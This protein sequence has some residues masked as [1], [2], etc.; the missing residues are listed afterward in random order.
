M[1]IGKKTS[2][3]EV[4]ELGH[5]CKCDACSV[6]CR[7][8]SG[9]LINEDIPK[10]AN[11]LKISEEVLKKEFLEEVEK[12]NTKLFRPKIIRKNK[13]Y[14]KC[15][16]FDEETGCKVHEVKP[17]ECKVSMGCKPYGEQLSVWFMLNNFV[18]EN[19]AESIRQYASYLKSGG[20]ILEGAELKD[21]VPDEDKL[22][23]ILK[24]EILK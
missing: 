6:G 13:P 17:Q 2:I 23:K 16:F 12:Y 18:N 3:K 11:F 10:I 20:K 5:P 19:D 4:L 9:F 1:M 21:L 22:N 14:G 8:G 24:F 7:H 15:I